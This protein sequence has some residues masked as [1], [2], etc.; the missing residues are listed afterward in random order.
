MQMDKADALS[1]ADVLPEAYHH[2]GR[3]GQGTRLQARHT[4]KANPDRLVKTWISR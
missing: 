2:S 3:S 1:Q 4:E